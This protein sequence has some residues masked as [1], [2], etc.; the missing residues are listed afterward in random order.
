MF[1]GP[2]VALIH[3]MNLKLEYVQQLPKAELFVKF[4]CLF[5]CCDFHEDQF[6]AKNSNFYSER[7]VN[8]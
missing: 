3:S 6:D 8:I 4:F 1:L 2:F 7:I 5:A